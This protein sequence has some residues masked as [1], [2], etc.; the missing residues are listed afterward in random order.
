MKFSKLIFYI[1]NDRGLFRRI[2]HSDFKKLIEIPISQIFY[3]FSNDINN[4]QTF[5]I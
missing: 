5:A 3:N 4:N 1:T 2:P